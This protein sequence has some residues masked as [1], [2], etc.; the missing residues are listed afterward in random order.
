[1]KKLFALRG[2]SQ[3]ENTAADMEKQTALLYDELLAANSLSEPD[4][5]SLVFSVTRDLDAANPAAVLRKSGRASALALFAVREAYSSG[6]LERTVRILIHC[7]MEDGAC[8]RHIYRNGAEVLRPDRAEALRES[9][10]PACGSKPERLT[11]LYGSRLVEKTHPVIVFRG[12]L[13]SLAAQI[14]EAQ[15]LGVEK[16]NQTFAAALQEILEFVRG[17]FSAEYNG[18]PLGEMRLLGMTSAELREKSHHPEKYFGETHLM[19]DYHAGA[20][21]VRLNSLRTAARETEIAAVAALHDRPD[22]V[23]ALNRLSS[24]FYILMYQ[25]RG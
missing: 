13:D 6:S 12:R 14:L 5:V 17:L 20:L 1:M 10:A 25:Y 16:E 22:I 15:V 2:A 18:T 3:C 11:H 4:I 19:P 23:E 21:C 24:L 9:G 7:F 8:P